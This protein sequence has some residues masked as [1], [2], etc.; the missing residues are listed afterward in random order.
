MSETITFLERQVLTALSQ[1]KQPNTV[2]DPGVT[3]YWVAKKA[4]VAQTSA[5]GAL[6]RLA[7]KGLAVK[8]FSAPGCLSFWLAG[9]SN[10]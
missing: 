8:T 6:R 9:G 4:G 3:V 2:S 1:H 5:Y 7:K 10:G